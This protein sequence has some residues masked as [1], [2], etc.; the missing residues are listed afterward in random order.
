MSKKKKSGNKQK[1]KNQKQSQS[2]NKEMTKEEFLK[3][4]AM[5]SKLMLSDLN[6]KP[7]NVYTQYTKD[8]Y[9]RY[10]QNPTSN[11][12]NIREMS[13]FLYR[14]SM[15]YRRFI[16]Y[17]SDIPLFLWNL[18]PI[19]D[20][21]GKIDNEK[22]L[23]DYTKAV[24]MIENMSLPFEFRNVVSTTIREG[25]FYGFIYS[26]KNSFFIHKLDPDYC[27]IKEIEGGCFNFAFDFSYFDKNKTQLDYM[28]PYFTTLYRTYEK[29]KKNFQWQILDPA[30]TICVKIDSD[31]Y[32]E[33][34]PQ[35]IGVFEAL[36]DLI[37]ARSLQRNKEEI[38]NYKLIVQKI[39][40][41]NS[42]TTID[43]F[44][45]DPDTAMGFYRQLSDVVPDQ[46]GVALSPMEI[47]TVTFQTDDN[48]N[49]LISSSMKA[50]F[51]D[52]G[53]AQ[54]LFNTE[55]SGAEGL[56]ASIRV[57]AG[58]VWKLVES[59]ER[60]VS[61][62]LQY[63]LSGRSKY[64]FEILRV[65]IFNQDEVCARELALANSGVP[66]KLKL[67]ASSGIPP[68][69][70]MSAEYFE[71]SILKIHEK[72]MPLQTS[73]T[74]SGKDGAIVSTGAPESSGGDGSGTEKEVIE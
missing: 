14:V 51:S 21:T 49:D 35:F 64:A 36:L 39:P 2:K 68:S 70:V 42:S 62:Y 61:R 38:Q 73:Y 29:D 7:S 41:F 58:M 33:I 54:L 34:L 56:D 71:N 44:S 59:I 32:D 5:L 40:T 11:E 72:W 4:K 67:A 20:L 23:K 48:S 37:D 50:V 57:D 52:S 22:I 19:T 66:N 69:R 27:A 17:I 25:V 63:N 47:D 16:N 65:D 26:D 28:D 24:N 18:T 15:P 8:L 13:N 60:W 3:Y 74:L 46:V 6:K 45:I 55:T 31:I 30:R 53:I 1:Q 9:R 12:A 10:I 43:D